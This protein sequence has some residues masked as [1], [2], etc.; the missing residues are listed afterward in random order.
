MKINVLKGERYEVNPEDIKVTF[1]DVKGVRRILSSVVF[2]LQI[3]LSSYNTLAAQD[4]QNRI[5]DL[6]ASLAILCLH[7]FSLH[8]LFYE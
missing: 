3:F 2:F 6:C 7:F 4:R 8:P 5:Y 1:N